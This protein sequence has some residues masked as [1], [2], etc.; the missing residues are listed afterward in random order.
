MSYVGANLLLVLAVSY[1][2]VD[3]LFPHIAV[4]KKYTA[5]LSF[6]IAICGLLFFRF[7]FNPLQLSHEP[8]YAALKNLTKAD[9]ICTKLMHREP[10]DQELSVTMLSS[11]STSGGIQG[12]Q[13]SARM[14]ISVQA[15]RPYLKEGGSTAIYY[16][17]LFI[18]SIYI[19]AIVLFLLSV[20]FF[21]HY[22]Y[23]K[24]S[25]AY[26][27]KILLLFFMFSLLELFH[28][29]SNI[30]SYSNE[31]IYDIFKFG[32]YFTILF[33]LGF[34][35]AFEH[36]LRFTLSVTGRYY[37]D[38]LLIDPARTTRWIDRIDT[39]ILRTFF[40]NTSGET[41]IG[42]TSKNNIKDS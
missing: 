27:D 15:L 24:P 13:D 6:S 40:K 23:G 8:D 11:V 38:V 9:S 32:H 4:I 37:E 29:V 1:S 16:R 30:H 18:I 14:A 7:L 28:H 10:T 26:I 19:N 35:Y 39:L 42:Y 5:G 36:K 2:I 12:S 3:Y 22:R 17:P 31:M 41:R 20:F 21:V 33:L 25:G 34:V